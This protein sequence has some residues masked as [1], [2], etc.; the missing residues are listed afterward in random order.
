MK[1]T[2]LDYQTVFEQ[3]A[4]QT[5]DVKKRSDKLMNYFLIGFFAGG[6]GLALF[7]DTWLIAFGVGGS[8]LVAY[9]S[10]KIALPDSNLYQYVLSVV[11]ALFMAQY[12]Y[13]THGMFEMHFF[14]FI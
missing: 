10:T 14:A 7:F 1:G 6:M 8:L 3:T 11:L 9:Y 2:T 5:L 12:I 4:K 13:Q